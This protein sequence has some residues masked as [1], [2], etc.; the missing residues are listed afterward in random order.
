ML[1]FYSAEMQYETFKTFYYPKTDLIREKNNTINCTFK[2]KT[3][4]NKLILK[5]IS[6]R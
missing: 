5:S 2:N 1:N 6:P 4:I 3:H